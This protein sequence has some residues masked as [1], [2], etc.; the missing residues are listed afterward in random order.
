[1][2]K[3]TLLWDEKPKAAMGHT[4]LIWISFENGG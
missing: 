3:K 4:V 1:M 2:S